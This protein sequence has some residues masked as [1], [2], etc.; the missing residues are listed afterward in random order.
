MKQANARQS[1]SIATQ[2]QK[3]QDSFQ[4]RDFQ[5]VSQICQ[6]ILQGQ[7]N[8]A[9]AYALLAELWMQLGNLASAE[10]FLALAQKFDARNVGYSIR[11]AQILIASENWDGAGQQLSQALMLDSNHASIYLLL[12]DVRSH[13]G[14]YE[15]AHRFFAQAEALADLPEIDEHRAYCYI[16]QQ[17]HANAEKALQRFLQRCPDAVRGWLLLGNVQ[18]DMQTYDAAEI[19]FDAAL[20]QDILAFEAFVGKAIIAIAR[21]DMEAAPHYLDRAFD[22][23]PDYYRTYFVLGDFLYKRRELEKS[24]SFVRQALERNPQFLPAQR[25]LA[26]TLFSLK[27]H[28]ESLE[29][30]ESYL[31]KMPQDEVMTFLCAVLRGDGAESAP[32]E[33]IRTLF[34]VYA[35]NFETHLV[36]GLG[37]KIPHE[38]L[39]ALQTVKEQEGDHRH[40]LSLLDIGCGTGLVAEAFQSL[41]SKRVG[42][43]LS[44]KMIEIA[45]E[46]NRYH[47]LII[48]DAVNYL[49]ET[50]E[51]FDLIT[52][53]DMLVYVGNPAALFAAVAERLAPHGYFILSVEKGEESAPFTLLPTGRFAHARG[54]IEDLGKQQGMVLQ[55]CHDTIIRMEAAQPIEGHLF[56]FQN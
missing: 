33:H 20:T 8:F 45:R 14:D 56:V 6:E 21:G 35:E 41:T 19:S 23:A 27:K 17:D 4:Q 46:K 40:D 54:A 11:R 42:I 15:S 5:Q 13:A 30:T 16:A 26:I 34:D 49:Q 1:V 25:L 50:T 43:D 2:F 48:G 32:S 22:I 39:A 38:M 12:A 52:A 7:E 18:L 31:Q 37:Y 44:P 24:E 53:A 51:S 55:T 28:E 10:K 29:L 9:P 47:H 36:E 3:A